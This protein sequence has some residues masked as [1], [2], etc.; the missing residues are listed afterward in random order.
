[1]AKH[2]CLS[3]KNYIPTQRKVVGRKLECDGLFSVPVYEDVP[4]HCEK[5]PRYF[6]KWWKENGNKCCE[7]CT[8]PKC[9]ELTDLTKALVEMNKLAQEILDNIDKKKDDNK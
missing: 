9:L 6:K 3:C 8:E 4:S 2:T 5:H 7:D 1:M